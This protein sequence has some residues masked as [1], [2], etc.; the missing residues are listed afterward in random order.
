MQSRAGLF[1]GRAECVTWLRCSATFLVSVVFCL[2]AEHKQVGRKWLR[3]LRLHT[4]ALNER[5]SFTARQKTTT[6]RNGVKTV[7]SE[8][9]ALNQCSRCRLIGLPERRKS[10]LTGIKNESIS[11][12]LICSVTF[13]FGHACPTSSLRI[14]LGFN[15]QLLSFCT[16]RL[17]VEGV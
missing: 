2:A 11:L 9:F 13:G 14:R 12:F 1:I 8:P 6:P 7:H 5:V 15:T 3:S 16:R 10:P 4:P 17:N